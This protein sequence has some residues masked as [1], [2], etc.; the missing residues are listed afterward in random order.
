MTPPLRIFPHRPSPTP[1]PEGWFFAA[2][3]REVEQSG[4]IQKQ[5]FGRDIVVWSN[6]QGRIGAAESWC[7]HLGSSLGPDAGGQVCNGRLVCPFHGFEFD[8]AGQCVHTP[9]APPP[10]SANLSTFETCEIDGLIFAWNGISGRSPQW[11]LPEQKL[12][13]TGWSA[14]RIWTLRFRGHPQD[15]TEN[16]VDLAH[17]RY[18]HGY[19]DVEPVEPALM[20]GPRLDARFNFKR[21]S[22]LTRFFTPTF[23]VAAHT[24]AVG[25]GYSLVEYRERVIGI[26]GRLW[27][28]A[29]PIDG[30]PIDFT[31]VSQIRGAAKPERPVVGLQ[32]LPGRLRLPLLNWLVA[33]QQQDVNDDVAI[34]SRKRYLTRPRLCRSDGKIM[35]YRAWC[36]QFYPAQEEAPPL[37]LEDPGHAQQTG[38]RQHA[39]G[40]R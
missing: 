9:F 25:L 29:T 5:W 6:E 3:R 32:F 2:S 11:R 24:I 14:K 10:R 37:S 22:R 17:L 15:T 30:E 7:P 40:S 33:S 23:D 26:E 31:L 12:D 38:R 28:L 35:P 20:D 34:W 1:F 18:V 36:A 4:L 13:Q 16:A 21:R 19:R 39:V 8:A 27:A